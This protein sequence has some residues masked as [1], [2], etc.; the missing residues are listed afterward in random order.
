[1]TDKKTQQN[2]IRIKSPMVAEKMTI[3]S[4]NESKSTIHRIMMTRTHSNEEE[5]FEK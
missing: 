1:M 5:V 3:F 2:D 4:F